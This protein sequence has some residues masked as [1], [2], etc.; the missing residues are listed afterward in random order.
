MLIDTT[1]P[2]PLPSANSDMHM[3]SSSEEDVE[4]SSEEDVEEL[5]DQEE[6]LVQNYDFEGDEDF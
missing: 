3:T 4:E 5:K 6:S 1:G 2:V